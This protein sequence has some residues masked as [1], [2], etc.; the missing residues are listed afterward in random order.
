[1]EGLTMVGLATGA[2][3]GNQLEPWLAF[4]W[5]RTVMDNTLTFVFV[6][7]AVGLVD[8]PLAWLAALWDFHGWTGNRITHHTHG[9]VVTDTSVTGSIPRLAGQFGFPVRS[10]TVAGWDTFVVDRAKQGG[11]FRTEAA[12]HQQKFRRNE[13]RNG[14]EQGGSIEELSV[15]TAAACRLLYGGTGLVDFVFWTRVVTGPIGGASPVYAH[16]S[17]CTHGS[18]CL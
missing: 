16:S 8:Q 11:V 15:V 4:D 14:G 1:M 6:A 18:V 9:V 10:D 13:R 3:S 12:L 7:A 2:M 17:C 5:I